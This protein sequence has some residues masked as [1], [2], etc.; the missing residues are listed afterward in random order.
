MFLN[1]EE[2]PGMDRSESERSPQDE[3]RQEKKNLM[4]ARSESLLRPPSSVNDQD[5]H[6]A[7][8]QVKQIE[9]ESVLCCARE[10]LE[11]A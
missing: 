2:G 6:T 3:K 11:F 8:Q 5:N 10:K 4:P 9:D 1:E 7:K